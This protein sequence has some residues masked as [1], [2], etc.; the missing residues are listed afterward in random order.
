M[1]R[2]PATLNRQFVRTFIY[3]F[4]FG[5]FFS[6][7]MAPTLAQ[8]AENS[9]PA[10][11]PPQKAPQ[12]IPQQTGR[13]PANQPPANRTPAA[14][15]QAANRKQPAITADPFKLTAK[16]VKRLEEVLGY[17][18][19]RSSKVKTYECKFV[20]WQYDSVF[21]PANPQQAKTQSDGII[22]YAAPDKGEFK[23]ERIG[24]FNP[25]TA[26][27]QIAMKKSDHDEHWI[28]DGERVFEL[29]GKSKTLREERLPPEMRGK[30][31]A[32]GPLPFMFGANRDDLMA[33]YW[34]KEVVPPNGR[35]DQFWIEARPKYR[36]DAANFQRILVILD[37]KVFLPT[38]MQVFPPTYDGKTN[39]SREAYVFNHRK[40]NDPLQLGRDFLG[41]FISPGVPRGW[42]KVVTN[43]GA[44]PQNPNQR[45]AMN[46]QAPTANRTQQAGRPSSTGAKPR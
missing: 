26:S 38:A 27:E 44:P 37:E 22:R 43:L 19:T 17:W 32:A 21:G 23:V 28:C 29:N 12:Q 31:I 13:P 33:R 18:Q 45:P 25:A 36:E 16:E 14:P 41:R 35:D 39:W 5:C 15:G 34:M 3:A 10:F 24:E 30:G 8:R 11:V 42:K 40:V 20:R 2:W 9:P 6:G 46:A 7:G 1:L 4:V